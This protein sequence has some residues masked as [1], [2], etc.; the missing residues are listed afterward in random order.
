MILKP[1]NYH[2]KHY[3]LYFI[4][5]AFI[6]NQEDKFRILQEVLNDNIYNVNSVRIW[7]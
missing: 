1:V 4:D 6:H 2:Y 3:L 5:E 7:S